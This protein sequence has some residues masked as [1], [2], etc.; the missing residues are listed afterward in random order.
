MTLVLAGIAISSVMTAGIDAVVTLVPDAVMG[1][2]AFRIGS[3]DGVTMKQLYLPGLY[4]GIALLLSTIGNKKTI[5]IYVIGFIFA[6]CVGLTTIQIA[7]VAAL[8][9]Y[10][11]IF[12]GGD[13]KSADAEEAEALPELE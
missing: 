13:K 1:V 7:I 6:K 12:V 10:L 5:P 3:L 8:I 9:A 2:S 4:I 11:M